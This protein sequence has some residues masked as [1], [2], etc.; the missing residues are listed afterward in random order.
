[1]QFSTKPFA[2]EKIKTGCAIVPVMPQR[3]LTA[4]GVALDRA[5]GG[6]LARALETGDLSDKSGSTLLVPVR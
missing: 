6:R 4:G 5:C 2:P 1:M 3:S